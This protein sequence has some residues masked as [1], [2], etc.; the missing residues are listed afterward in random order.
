M[1]VGGQDCFGESA[2]L[3]EIFPHYRL[4]AE[5]VLAGARRALAAKRR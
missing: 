4:T 2:P 1:R 5:G 3:T